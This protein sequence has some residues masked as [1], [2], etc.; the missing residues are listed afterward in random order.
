MRSA[1]S[2][3]AGILL[4]TNISFAQSYL[5]LDGSSSMTGTLTTPNIH[6]TRNVS[7]DSSLSA[8]T[9]RS[10]GDADFKQMV[11]IAN[12]VQLWGS[13]IM[14]AG[15]VSASG[16]I[17]T[18]NHL[19]ADSSFRAGSIFTGGSFRA[20]GQSEFKG[21]LYINSI[22][23]Y[24][25]FTSQG[26]ITTTDTIRATKFI[27]DGSRLTN[28]SG[29]FGNRVISTFGDVGFG[30]SPLQGTKLSVTGSTRLNGEVTAQSVTVTNNLNVTTGYVGVGMTPAAGQK[31]AVN[32]NAAFNGTIAANGASF[33]TTNITSSGNIGVGTPNPAAP[34]DIV[35]TGQ[36][37]ALSFQI[38]GNGFL[39]VNPNPLAGSWNPLVSAGDKLL[40]F[41]GGTSETGSLVIGQWSN[42]AK[43]IKINATGNVGIGCQ[44]SFST[45]ASACKLS[46][47]GKIG[48]RDVVVTVGAFPDFV[49]E[50]GY[51]LK[52]LV[53]VEKNIKAEGHLEGIPSKKEVDIN[54]VA[55]GK[56]QAKIL[57]KVEELT[58]YAIQQDKR[59]E[60]QSQRI[61]QLEKENL[62]LQ[63]GR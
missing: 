4:A 43:G 11:Y 58:L 7:V 18:R 52:P 38:S 41:S 15:K 30:T 33:G 39:A 63:H 49:F 42:S 6:C 57:Q 19:I 21:L 35:K 20:D 59:L 22:Y 46:V 29:A 56:L 34:L 27:G 53:E 37:A 23:S 48:A 54:G 61:A 50:Q 25:P 47:E 45:G 24:G 28:L 3:V 5:P 13:D 31:L 26:A 44:P 14:N 40:L 62:K 9:F 1:A 55:I 17:E 60:E 10:W 32:G 2:V 16:N 8:G 12:G 51:N 36:S